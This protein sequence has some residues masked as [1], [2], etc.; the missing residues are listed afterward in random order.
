MEMF[1][2]LKG[3]LRRT[4]YE[5]VELTASMSENEYSLHAK[6]GYVQ[7]HNYNDCYIHVHIMTVINGYTC[8]V[9]HVHVHIMT[10]INGYMYMYI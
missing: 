6:I 2:P 9:I 10:V 1:A 4:N 7:V 8:T 5:G 3:S